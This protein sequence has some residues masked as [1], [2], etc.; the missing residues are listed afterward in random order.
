MSRYRYI[1]KAEEDRVK[2][3]RET[4]TAID[5]ARKLDFS[6]A[7]I[8]RICVG[9]VNRYERVRATD[10]IYRPDIWDRILISKGSLRLPPES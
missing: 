3:M 10:G 1:T 2:V 6:E 4:M 8:G 5:I 7:T 9:L